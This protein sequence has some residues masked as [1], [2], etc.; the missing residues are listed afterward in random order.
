M[1][2]KYEVKSATRC[3]YKRMQFVLHIDSRSDHC[4]SHLL[5]HLLISYVTIFSLLEVNMHAT[6][7]CTFGSQAGI[8]LKLV[9]VHILIPS[10]TDL[11]LSQRMRVWY[12]SHRR[13]ASLPCSH[14]CSMKVEEGSDQKSDV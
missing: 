11:K 14:T 6:V 12:L 5:S 8:L 4:C 1:P 10:Q 9:H 7:L 3:C 2:E 13:P